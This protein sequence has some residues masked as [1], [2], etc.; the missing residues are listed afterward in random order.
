MKLNRI[1]IFVPDIPEARQFYSDVLGV[2]IAAES[3]THLSF[4]G[5]GCE[6]MAYKCEKST[7]IGDYGNEARSVLVFEVPDLEATL[8]HLRAHNVTVLH[9]TPGENES[10]RYAAFVDPFG[11]VHEVFVPRREDE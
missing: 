6:F 5:A 3:K 8:A 9:A 4:S 11:I 7:T 2:K 1:M 10:G